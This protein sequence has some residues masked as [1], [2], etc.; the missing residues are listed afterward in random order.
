VDGSGRTG[1]T[2]APDP[3]V[4]VAAVTDDGVSGDGEAHVQSHNGDKDFE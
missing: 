4:V 1:R 2:Y 3:D